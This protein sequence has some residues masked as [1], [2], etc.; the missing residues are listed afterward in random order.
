MIKLTISMPT[1]VFS[2]I[3]LLMIAY[4]SR[5]VTLTQVI[6]NL[7]D[8]YLSQ[9][10]KKTAAQINSLMRRVRYIR[11]MQ[12]AALMAFA[13]NIL[14][15][16]LLYFKLDV[17]ASFLFFIGLSLVFISLVICIIEVTLSAQALEFL[18]ELEAHD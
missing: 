10:E 3:S 1:L 12:I 13:I 7:H 14:T 16:I 5:Y 6:R 4:T 15:M 2:A 11:N 18:L 8:S 17:I 9:P